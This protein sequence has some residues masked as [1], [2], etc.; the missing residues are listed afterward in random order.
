MIDKLNLSQTSSRFCKII[1]K[2]KEFARFRS[3]AK[4][5]FHNKITAYSFRSFA[6]TF[7]FKFYEKFVQESDRI[8]LD[9]VFQILIDLTGEKI[10][11]HM[12]WCKRNKFSNNCDL[13][14]KV[15]RFYNNMPEG[16]VCNKFYN[17]LWNKRIEKVFDERYCY[18][19]ITVKQLCVCD[20]IENICN[21][22]AFI[23]FFGVIA[24]RI[25]FNISRQF[26]FCVKL[27]NKEIFFD[28]FSEQSKCIFR[29]LCANDEIAG[30]LIIKLKPLNDYDPSFLKITNEH[31]L[32]YIQCT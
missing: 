5:I 22:A 14:I 11:A 23:I 27:R 6:R 10:L 30:N 24:I 7:K 15:E 29:C 28:F 20:N 26:I 19:A 16:Y 25:F 18:Q 21:T 12:L 31:Y 3:Y 2:Q 9:Y 1:N 32:L 4:I 8:Y 17:A 13:C